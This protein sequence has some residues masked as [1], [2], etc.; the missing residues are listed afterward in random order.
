MDSLRFLEDFENAYDTF[1]SRWG[2]GFEIVNDIDSK[3]VTFILL[4]V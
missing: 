2:A 3:S 1:G 4:A